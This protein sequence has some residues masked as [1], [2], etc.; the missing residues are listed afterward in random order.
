MDPKGWT[1][2]RRFLDGAAACPGGGPK[3]ATHSGLD[4]ALGSHPCVALSSYQAPPLY[5]GW[6]YR[7]NKN[8][9]LWK[10]TAINPG[11]LGGQSPSRNYHQKCGTFRTDSAGDSR[12]YKKADRRLSN[13]CLAVQVFASKGDVPHATYIHRRCATDIDRHKRMTRKKMLSELQR[14]IEGQPGKTSRI[15]REFKQCPQFQQCCQILSQALQHNTYGRKR[16]AT[17]APS[18][19]APP[20]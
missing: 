6:Q 11:G 10:K 15:V 20:G 2:F 8:H 9:P 7:P 1:K 12:R 18:G 19:L 5:G 14:V 13:S 4:S 3:A 17:K 16:S